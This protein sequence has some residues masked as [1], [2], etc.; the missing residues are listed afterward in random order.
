MVM[1]VSARWP[2]AA[3]L[4]FGEAPST[5]ASTQ[6]IRDGSATFARARLLLTLHAAESGGA[7]RA[8]PCANSGR[9]ELTGAGTSATARHRCKRTENSFTQA[10]PLGRDRA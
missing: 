1:E 5:D 9:A 8:P 2:F 6:P 4:R 7:G 10:R 3:S